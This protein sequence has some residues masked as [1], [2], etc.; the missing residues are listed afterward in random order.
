MRTKAETYFT[1]LSI[2]AAL[3]RIAASEINILKNCEKSWLMT[4]HPNL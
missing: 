2:L 4:S 3:R 1:L